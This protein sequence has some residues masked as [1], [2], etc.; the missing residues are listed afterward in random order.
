M[1]ERQ[2]SSFGEHIGKKEAGR[3]QNFF[4][5]RMHLPASPQTLAIIYDAAL[6]ET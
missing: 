4:T 1:G 6:V 3:R 5:D 2:N